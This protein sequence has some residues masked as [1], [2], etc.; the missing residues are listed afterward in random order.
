MTSRETSDGDMIAEQPAAFGTGRDTVDG[1]GGLYVA[2]IGW[3]ESNSD[4]AAFSKVGE[5]ADVC[6]RKHWSIVFTL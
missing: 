6:G 5:M 1:V 4:A 3:D 2:G